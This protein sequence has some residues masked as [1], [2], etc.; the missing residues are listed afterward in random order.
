VKLSSVYF[1]S[2]LSFPALR[3]LVA[4]GLFVAL[5]LGGGLSC[6]Q[7]VSPSSQIYQIPWPDESGQY[8]L[9]NVKVESLEKPETLKGK[10]VAL[11]V[12]P[13][14]DGGVLKGAKPVGRFVRISEG[15]MVPADYVSL[16]ATVVHAHF[17]RLHAI[18]RVL[19]IA[20]KVPWPAK[21]GIEADVVDH[22]GVVRDN[23]VFEKRLNALLIVPYTRAELPIALNAGVL[24]HEHFHRVFQ[25]LVL[26]HLKVSA[27]GPDLTG[28]HHGSVCDW[29]HG[30]HGQAYEQA[31]EVAGR[32][33]AA[34]VSP[35]VSPRGSPGVSGE[36]SAEIYNSVL[37]RG[38]NEG[39]A[40]FW[41]WMYTGQSQ[42]IGQS[43]PMENK[44]RRL[45]DQAPK[46]PSTAQLKAMLWDHR[47]SVPLEKPFRIA[48]SY[49][50]GT[51]YARL[52]REL[53]LE[54]TGGEEKNLEG[55]MMMAQAVIEALVG[56]RQEAVN[57]QE[58][59]R[60]LS[61]N[62]IL[63]PLMSSLP[64]AKSNHG[65]RLLERAAADDDG[66]SGKPI[67]CLGE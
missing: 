32:Q 39:L 62:L 33:L 53:T 44:R 51:R 63:K 34:G 21:I 56:V 14:V 35:R 13:Y 28:H 37:L 23:A 20:D 50:L 64:S 29:P 40:D 61:A 45:D 24:A 41:G 22:R 57:A 55:R 1:C 16:Q 49:E 12:D 25:A 26:D 18:D 17:E 27:S 2:T 59:G 65:C 42:F 52:L 11:L 38:L 60:Y 3:T 19:G 43:L 15:I 5:G 48:I 4:V 66:P 54:L 10:F 6:S 9:Q 8:S 67:G 58:Q 47:S 7:F 30:A 31:P 46:L 36:V